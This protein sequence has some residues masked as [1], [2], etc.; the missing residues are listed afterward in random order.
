LVVTIDIPKNSQI[1]S[2]YGL[3]KFILFD[4]QVCSF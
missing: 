2:V 4:F 1:V 3:H